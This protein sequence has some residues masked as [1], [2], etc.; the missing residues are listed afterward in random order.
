MIKLTGSYGSC[1][2]TH[3]QASSGDCLVRICTRISYY[4]EIVDEF[5]ILVR[6]TYVEINNSVYFNNG[7]KYLDIWRLRWIVNNFI[8][9]WTAYWICPRIHC[10][11]W[12]V[13]ISNSCWLRESEILYNYRDAPNR[14]DWWALNDQFEWSCDNLCASTLLSSD[15]ESKSCRMICII[16]IG[17]PMNKLRIRSVKTIIEIGNRIFI[18]MPNCV[19]QGRAQCVNGCVRRKFKPESW[20][21]SVVCINLLT[22]ERA[23]GQSRR[24][25]PAAHLES[26]LGAF[27]KSVCW[28]HPNV[29][30][31]GGPHLHQGFIDV[32]YHFIAFYHNRIILSR[33]RRIWW[34]CPIQGVANLISHIAPSW[35]GVGIKLKTR[36]AHTVHIE[37]LWAWKSRWWGEGRLFCVITLDYNCE[38]VCSSGGGSIWATCWYGDSKS[39]LSNHLSVNQDFSWFIPRNSMCIKR[40]ITTG[41]TKESSGVINGTVWR[42]WV[43]KKNCLV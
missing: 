30:V 7:I 13:R 1:P 40:I 34:W 32:V 38:C 10:P 41:R 18:L 36:I 35:T 43:H 22:I 6:F 17:N 2:T 25:R 5:L 16:S 4:V 33:K 37:K 39:V 12:L 11:K 23:L 26:H 15:T 27:E 24:A 8:S 3:R 20:P 21:R 28:I 29:E 19:S 31:V 14:S 42:V 9:C